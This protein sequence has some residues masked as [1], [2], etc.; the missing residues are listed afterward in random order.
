VAKEETRELLGLFVVGYML[1][2]LH[3]SVAL[4]G[5]TGQRAIKIAIWRRV[6]PTFYTQQQVQLSGIA[7]R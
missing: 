3:R 6:R 7:I 4:I 1:L 2:H 5:R